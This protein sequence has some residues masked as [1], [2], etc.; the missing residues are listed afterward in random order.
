[1]VVVL[2]VVVI[3]ASA[4]G[5]ER[6]GG[7]FGQRVTVPGLAAGSAGPRRARPVGQVRVGS[8]RILSR[9]VVKSFCQGQRA[10]IRRV[11]WRLVRVRRAGI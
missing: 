4:F 1:M 6:F 9:T 3:R 2:V 7:V 8:A 5:R 11:H 10:G